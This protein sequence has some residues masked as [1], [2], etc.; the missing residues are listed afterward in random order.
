MCGSSGEIESNVEEDDYFDYWNWHL[1]STGNYGEQKK[2]VWTNIV[3]GG[4]DQLCQRTAFAL[5]Q[6][7]AISPDFLT[8]PNLCKSMVLH[9]TSSLAP[10]CHIC[11]TSF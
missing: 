10:L 9:M 2:T 3:L 7:F 1:D 6:I 11:D 5:S 8:Y 4:D